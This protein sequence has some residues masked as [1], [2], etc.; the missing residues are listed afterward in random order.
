MKEYPLQDKFRNLHEKIQKIHLELNPNQIIQVH[1]SNLENISNRLNLENYK[2]NKG[3]IF[4]GF[5]KRK[6]VRDAVQ[7]KIEYELNNINR[8]YA[9]TPIRRKHFVDVNPIDSDNVIY[10]PNKITNYI[11][12]NSFSKLNREIKNNASVNIQNFKKKSLIISQGKVSEI[13]IFSKTTKPKL[14]IL[15]NQISKKIQYTEI[16]PQKEDLLLKL[17]SG[18]ANEKIDFPKDKEKEEILIKKTLFSNKNNQRISYNNLI[19]P[20]K[21]SFPN[22]FELLDFSK[23]LNLNTNNQSLNHFIIP[24]IYHEISINN[25]SKNNSQ[26]LNAILNNQIS[27]DDKGAHYNMKTE[28]DTQLKICLPAK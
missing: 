17:N 27:S 19:V 15:K 28:A 7:R 12:H 25:A 10:V 18:L 26:E 5:K 24:Q 4:N 14:K 20:S 6:W 16:S 22:S 1:N 23:T 2:K 11:S 3:Y 13:N 8:S 21:F 9:Y